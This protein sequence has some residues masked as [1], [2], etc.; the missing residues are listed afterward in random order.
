MKIDAE[1]LRLQLA[2]AM[3]RIN[4]DNDGESPK[5]KEQIEM[6]IEVAKTISLL[7]GNMIDIA[8]MEVSMA[9][10][11]IKARKQE[12]SAEGLMRPILKSKFFT[13]EG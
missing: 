4:N 1:F 10:T 2:E 6:D 13:E 3:L 9:Q 11:I 12:A 7:A 8:K 5:T